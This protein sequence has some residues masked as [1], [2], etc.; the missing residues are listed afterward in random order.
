MAKEKGIFSF[1]DLLGS[2]DTSIKGTSIIRETE[3]SSKKRET[4]S[5][6]IY[7]LNAAL[8]GSLFGGIPNNRISVFAGESGS[9]KSFLCYNVCRQAQ[10]AGYSI[11]YIDT[12]FSIEMDQLPGYGLNISD[13]KFTLIRSNIIEDIKIFLTKMLDN[14]KEVKNEGKQIPK[15][16]LVLDSV[17]MLASRK[18]VEDAK[19]G[20]EKADMTSAKAAASLFRIINADLGYL[21]IPALFTNH[22][23]KTMDLFPQ[24]KMKKGEGLYYS[25]S[26]IAF[27][28]KAQLKTG[29]E[30]ELDLGRSGNVVTAK[31]VKNRMAKPKKVKFEISFVSGCN[32]Y[33]GLDYWCNEENMEQIGICKGKMVEGKFVAGGNRWYVDHLGTHVRGDELFTPKVF[34]QKVLESM[35][36]II[37]DYFKF[38]SITEIEE[39]NARIAEAKG[40]ITDKELYGADSLDSSKLFSDEDED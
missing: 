23:Y 30:D 34:T 17:G 22:T 3:K 18:E 1:K 24:D 32:P 28:S 38:K 37:N 6:G 26:N 10:K 2:I 16:L 25:A 39:I 15:I 13:D 36:P 5:T 4:I 33:V 7:V 20:K 27:L 19:G 35:E 14:L 8:S 40:N 12:E 21:N 11:I 31:M 29:N 9:G